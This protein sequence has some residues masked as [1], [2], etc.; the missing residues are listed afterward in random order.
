MLGARLKTGVE[1]AE[2]LRAATFNAPL[3]WRELYTK[4]EVTG[5]ETI[6][7]EPCYKIVLTPKQGNPETMYFQKKS[8]FAVK[9]AMIT[10]SP[11]G[12]TPAEMFESDYK[13][14]GG[15]MTPTKLT[16]KVSQLEFTIT[17]DDVKINQALPKD[18]FEP[19][20]EVKALIAK[21]KK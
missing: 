6:D 15:I 10:V 3:H 9:T 4:V 12:E 7:S 14:L 2:A 11:M 1:G 5:S 19:P 20:A 18:R 17:F 13:N 16:T 21:E 8:G